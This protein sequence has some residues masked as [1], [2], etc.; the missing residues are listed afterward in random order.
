MKKVM[1]K[2]TVRETWA[3]LMVTIMVV[4]LAIPTCINAIAGDS[5]VV[6]T[7]SSGWLESANVEWSPVTNATGY[8]VYYKSATAADT[9]YTKIDDLLVRKYNTYIRADAV[10]LSA[11]NYIM[12]VVPI[13]NGTESTS[14]QAVTSTLTVTAYTREGFAFSTQSTAKTGSGG[15]NDN[16]TVAA[17]AQIVYVTEQTKNTVKASVITSSS[18]SLTACTGIGAIL[19]ARSKGYDT[20]PLIL[21][22]VGKVTMFSNSA[23]TNYMQLKST[24]KLT[25]EGIGE[26]ATLYGLGILIRDC[27]NIEV[28]N[29]GIMM[30]PDDGVSLDTDN[31]NIWIHNNDIF[32]G[33]PGSDADQVKGDGSCDIKAFSN[34]ISV[35]Y[36]HFWDSGKCSLCGMS[37]TKEFFVT[38]DHNWFDHSDSRQ[39]RIRVGTIHVYNN[40]FDGNSKYGVGVT[41]GSS[42]F[43]ENNYFRNCKYP[44]LSSLQGSDV[45]GG[46]EGTFSSEAGGI[47][48]SY[49]NTIIGATRFVD[50][51]YSATD[52][53]AIT[54]S[55]RNATVP[56]SYKTVSGGTTYNNFDTASTMYKYTVDTP[57]AAKVKVEK[58]AGR[59]NGGDFK[60]NF[61]DSV[62]DVSYDVNAALKSAITSYTSNLVS[63]GGNSAGGGSSTTSQAV[64]Q[65]TTQAATQTTTQAATQTTTQAAT[66]AQAVTKVH[67]FTTSGKTSSFFTISGNLSTSKGT[68]AYNGLTLTQCLKMESATSVKFT[69]AN[70]GKLTLVFVESAA[71]VNVNGTQYTATKGIVT[72]SVKAGAVS[73]TKADT[74]NLF[75]IDFTTTDT[76]PATTQAATQATTQAA[77]QQATT[78]A[79]TQATTQAATQTTTQAATQAQAVTKV[80]NFTTSGKTSSFFTISGNLSTSKGSVTYNGLT[81][82]QCLKMESATSVKFTAADAGKLTLVFVESAA[83]VNVNGTQYTATKGIVTVSVKAGAVSITKADTANLFYIDFTTTSTTPATT[84]AA[85]QATTP[86]TTQS[87]TQTTTQAETTTAPTQQDGYDQNSTGVV[88][89]IKGMTDSQFKT[90]VYCAPNASATGAGTSSSPMSLEAAITLSNATNG[91]AIILQAGTYSYNYQI[92]I[93]YGNNGTSSA[94]KVLKAADGAKVTLDFSTQTYGDT[95]TNARGLQMEGNYWYIYGITVTGSAD[96]GIFVAGSHNV[97][98]RCIVKANRDSGLQISRRNSTLSNMA[99]WP[100]NNYIINCTSYDNMDPA[101]QENAD[102]FS[103]KLTC[104]EGNVFDGC[105]SYCNID[106]GWDLYAKT[107]TGSIGVVTIRNCI[108]FNNGT[109]TNGTSSS[110]GDRNGFKLGGSNGAV[111]TPHKVFNCL[112]FSNGKDGFTDNGNG[113]ALTITNCTSCNNSGSNFNFYRTNGGVYTNLLT[114]SGKNT[115]KFVGTIQNALYYN[116][117]SYYLVSTKTAVTSGLKIGTVITAPSSSDLVSMTAP[118][119]KSDI[120]SL[121]R[122]S[123]GSVSS[124]GYLIA[125]NSGTFG[126]LGAEF[127]ISTSTL[128]VNVATK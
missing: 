49:G 53:D 46:A 107:E 86:A 4:T 76:T 127:G 128:K 42:A 117:G 112:S 8:S 79:A 7:G 61:N 83:T 102:G 6:I 44:M 20:R 124:N 37:D 39:P 108:S 57:E 111:P 64:T 5:S 55:S 97:V 101:T 27:T 25:V 32:Y 43:V 114:I 54:T 125:K 38:Y 87:A 1:A 89:S 71:T 78:Q 95:S 34:F 92:T 66:Q 31:N 82:T 84:Q 73:I 104:G 11:G 48:K 67:N 100:A 51:T 18:G 68:V 96:N 120:D 90:A 28:R 105:I 88:T 36:N 21:R 40:F 35:S 74:A 126:T 12:K 15:Y 81:L 16:G 56:S 106:D 9:A 50:Q 13:I 22:V 94:Y 41:K 62:D 58:Y 103:A 110:S 29:I 115:D 113:A 24:Q 10:G 26:D 116:G 85:T 65:A 33:A 2:K 93:P 69:A 98:E 122:N 3:W 72:V 17:N 59:I 119:V 118:N 77:T 23:N 99:D 52:F 63:I 14:N 121:Y 30:F 70:A 19:T 91:I 60:W 123:D 45:Y 75:Y 80:H 109:L 47:I